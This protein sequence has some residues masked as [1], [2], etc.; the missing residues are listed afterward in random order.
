MCVCLCVLEE[1]I[2]KESVQ[3]SVSRRE[4]PLQCVFV[5]VCKTEQV[6][7]DTEEKKGKN[8]TGTLCVCVCMCVC[9][10]LHFINTFIW[11]K[12]SQYSSQES[13]DHFQTL[14]SLSRLASRQVHL[15]LYPWRKFVIP[16]I[17]NILDTLCIL[18][19]LTVI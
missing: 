6:G 4:T 7:G 15:S 17:S 14:W 16:A 13:C 9:V 5:L 11:D 2:E 12:I 8:V 10:T 1:E 18:C 19:A 3:Y